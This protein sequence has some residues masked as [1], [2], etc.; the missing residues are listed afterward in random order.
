MPT[1][2]SKIFMHALQPPS[3]KQTVPT[4]DQRFYL[5]SRIHAG[6]ARRCWWCTVGAAISTIR[7]RR[8]WPALSKGFHTPSR[9]LARVIRHSP[10]SA[11]SRNLEG[12]YCPSSMWVCRF[13]LSP[14]VGVYA[15]GA[16]GMPAHLQV[17]SP[18]ALEVCRRERKGIWLRLRLWGCVSDMRRR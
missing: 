12:G 4:I 5:R 3:R 15:E 2:V 6:H 8:V 1:Y 14:V 10:F 11:S 7:C 17:V 9:S 13:I 16:C 18:W